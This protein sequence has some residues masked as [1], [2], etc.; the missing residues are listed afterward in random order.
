MFTFL[1]IKHLHSSRVPLSFTSVTRSTA[2]NPEHVACSGPCRWAKPETVSKEEALKEEQCDATV[3]DNVEQEVPVCGH[4]S[5]MSTKSVGKPSTRSVERDRYDSVEQIPVPKWQGDSGDSG[6][7]SDNED[8]KQAI[9]V[10]VVE[11]S[12][13]YST[14]SNF[15]LDGEVCDGYERNIDPNGNN[16]WDTKSTLIEGSTVEK[17]FDGGGARGTL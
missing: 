11:G 14:S 13:F 12:G 9:E 17:F 6:L 16:L 10:L 5:S 4:K 7:P 15:A 1:C 2:T 3:G 8:R